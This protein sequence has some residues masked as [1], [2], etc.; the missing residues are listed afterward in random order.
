M[1]NQ[2][3]KYEKA[4]RGGSFYPRYQLN[5]YWPQEKTWHPQNMQQLK[6]AFIAH[7]EVPLSTCQHDAS[8]HT[9]IFPIVMVPGTFSHIGPHYKLYS[10][11]TTS[12][13][14]N[15][16]TKVMARLTF[17]SLRHCF[18]NF[19]ESLLIESIFKK[20]S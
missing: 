10:C 6:G 7:S 8:I 3:N 2:R 5:P 15:K 4:A 1:E 16:N 12:P 13:T 11:K 18:P 9:Q 14:V 17:T 20:F 19:F